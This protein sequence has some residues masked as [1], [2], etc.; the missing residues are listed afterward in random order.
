MCPSDIICLLCSEIVD[1]NSE[2]KCTVKS[3]GIK[4][5]KAASIIRGD[6]NIHNNLSLLDKVV[7]HQ[8]CYVSYTRKRDLEKLTKANKLSNNENKEENV[9][10]LRSSERE[11]NFKT[12]CFFCGDEA[13]KEQDN[14]YPK[15]QRRGIGFVT[16]LSAKNNILVAPG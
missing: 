3:K 6:N 10:A 9:R 11:F 2:N 15:E 7:L 13:N 12:D 5:L 8:L 1:L 14:K 16:L 4:S